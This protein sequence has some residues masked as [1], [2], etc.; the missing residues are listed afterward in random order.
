LAYPD[1]F[2]GQRRALAALAV[3]GAVLL[4]ACGDGSTGPVDEE[5]QELVGAWRAAKYEFARQDGSG[6]AV[7]LASLGAQVTVTIGDGGDWTVLITRPGMLYYDVSTG[8]LSVQGDTI[9]LQWTG[10]AEPM[11]FAFDLL[12]NTLT[13]N[14]PDA[15]YDFDT[16]GTLD[17]ADLEMVLMRM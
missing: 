5:L 10:Q 15:L 9:L 13:M 1:W 17:P 6:E 2:R 8:R 12:D 7:N 4:S 3:S 16:D 11:S 14:T